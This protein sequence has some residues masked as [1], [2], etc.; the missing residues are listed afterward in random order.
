MT[1]FSDRAWSAH[2]RSP[3]G[4][5]DAV[6]LDPAATVDDVLKVADTGPGCSVKDSFST[7]DLSPR[8][9]T[10]LFDAQWIHREPGRAGSGPRL[11]WQVVSTPAELAG[12]AAAHGNR[13][14]LHRRPAER[15]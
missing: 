3:H 7:L 14:G 12:F 13:G 6:C 1:T 8:G 15:R 9:F 5:P 11:P 10:V 4:Y 2:S